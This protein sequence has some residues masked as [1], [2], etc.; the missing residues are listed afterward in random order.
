MEG[1]VYYQST[2]KIAVG[3]QVAGQTKEPDERANSIKL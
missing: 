1:H 3:E 2:K